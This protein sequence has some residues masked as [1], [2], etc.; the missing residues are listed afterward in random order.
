MSY[1]S[2]QGIQFNAIVA[3]AVNASAEYV[4]RHK[5]M[6]FWPVVFVSQCAC[7]VMDQELRESIFL[8][9]RLESWPKDFLALYFIRYHLSDG[10]RI[11]FTFRIVPCLHPVG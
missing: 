2:R 8:S 1:I 10:H 4:F 3:K 5:C 11:T 7:K 6:F 9:L